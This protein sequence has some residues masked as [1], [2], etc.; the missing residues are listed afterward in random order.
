M[1]TSLLSRA[2]AVHPFRWAIYS[3]ALLVCLF[4][5]GF[6][7]LWPGWVEVDGLRTALRIQSER[8]Q[9][10]EEHTQS[11]RRLVDQQ[12]A[13]ARSD[14]RIYL[15]NELRHV[16]ALIKQAASAHGSRCTRVTL[17]K[18]QSERWGGLQIQALRWSET[19]A[20]AARIESRVVVVH[21]EGSFE[22]IYRTVSA[23]M[24]QQQAFL[25]ERWDLVRTTGGGP[26]RATIS[27]T[28]FSVIEGDEPPPL[29]AAGAQM[30]EVRG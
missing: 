27:A 21:L 3:G 4:V 8:E 7:I 17:T 23:L 25:P 28:L 6:T 16:P 11:I 15:E 9:E 22:G 12:R 26:V 20:S 5:A 10:V 14:R 19:A 30:A 1:A 13:W 18:R 29:P 2:R 24:S